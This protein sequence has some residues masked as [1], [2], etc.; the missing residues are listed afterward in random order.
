MQP[1][2]FKLPHQRSGPFSIGGVDT[3]SNI[4]GRIRIPSQDRLQA[5]G[6][7]SAAARNRTEGLID[8]AERGLPRMHRRGAFAHR[9]R[10]VETNAGHSLRREGDSL[11]CGPVLALGLACI[12]VEA[13]RRILDGSTAADLAVI[14]ATRAELCSDAGAIALAVW[15]AAE[16]AELHAASLLHRLG[17]LMA[18]DTPMRTVDC[19]WTLVAALAAAHLADATELASDAARRLVV[20]QGASG[21]FPDM[22]P[23]SGHG[24][25]R[26]HAGCFADQAHAIQAL[27]RFHAARGDAAA[28][29][30]AN[31]CAERICKLQG[32]DGQWWRLYDVRDASIVETYP[33]YSV[34]QHA[35]APMALLDLEEC[36]GM[37]DWGAVVKG[38]DWL[39]Q[40]PET[41]TPLICEDHA[42][43]WR[44]A[45]RRGPGKA[46]GA[47]ARR[48]GLP[49]PWLDRIF[50]PN[51]VELECRPHE[52][53]WLLYAWLSGG[54]VERLRRAGR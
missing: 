37:A 29:A 50:P 24:R 54:R 30:A 27:A 16:V 8:L 17:V 5:L 31:A 23:A 14:A 15:A 48:C 39:Y 1:I 28:L 4:A 46:I 3:G 51:R 42:A 25:S 34:H 19:A 26:T 2:P 9:I 41:V 32:R 43:I 33:I 38:V 45:A 11:R 18:A 49:L 12:D 7:V 13:Q 10:I 22:L 6:A 44:K 21:L 20:A 52:M 36:G 47:T 40:H 53:G 35:I